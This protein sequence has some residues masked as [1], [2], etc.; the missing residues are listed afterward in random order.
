MANANRP[1]MRIAQVARGAGRAAKK[2]GRVMKVAA[3]KVARGYTY[4]PNKIGKVVSAK[5]S[6]SVNRKFARAYSRAALKKI[7]AAF[8][9]I[10]DVFGLTERQFSALKKTR[11]NAAR[12]AYAVGKAT[13]LKRSKQ[14]GAVAGNAVKYAT[15]AAPPVAAAVVISTGSDD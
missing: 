2:V 12:S 5:V 6:R 3:K 9:S 1:A 8:G 13:T 7:D 11:S 14:I 10:D 4:I 15:I